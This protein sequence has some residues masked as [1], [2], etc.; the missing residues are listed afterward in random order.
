LEVI[1]VF[2]KSEA[3]EVRVADDDDFSRFYN[4]KIKTYYKI[5]LK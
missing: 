4:F 2:L 1:A 5:Y 3:S